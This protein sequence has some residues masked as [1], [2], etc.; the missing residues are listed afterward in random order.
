MKQI[1]CSLQNFSVASPSGIPVLNQLNLNI[2]S[3]EVILL[4]GA[5]GSG[6]STLLNA[7]SGVLDQQKWTVS[8]DIVVHGHSDNTVHQE[9]GIGSMVFQNFAL[10]DELT[11]I[12]NVHIALDHAPQGGSLSHKSLSTLLD[13]VLP[14]ELIEHMSGGQKQR[15]AI[16]RT[17]HSGRLVLLFDEPN[18]GLDIVNTCALAKKI[19]QLAEEEKRAVIIVAHHFQGFL[20]IIDRVWFLGKNGSIKDVEPQAEHIEEM[21]IQ[22]SQSTVIQKDNRSETINDWLPEGRGFH[23]ARTRWL[24]FFFKH[25]FSQLCSS[26]LLLVYM[27]IGGIL[28]GFVS[29]WF[30]IQNLP[31]KRYLLEA[32]HDELLSG[33]GFFQFRVL[34]PLITS[35][36]LAG[37]NGAIISADLGHRVHASQFK[38]MRNLRLPYKLYFFASMVVN[39]ILAAW[40]MFAVVWLIAAWVSLGTWMVLYPNHH[41]GIWHELFFRSYFTSQTTLPL[42]WGWVASKMALSGVACSIAAIVAGFSAKS[43]VLDINRGI[44]ISLVSG[45]SAV[46]LIHTVFAFLEF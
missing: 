42:G 6:K 7:L 20:S 46:L 9:G 1:L 37:R 8:G 17:L 35:L 33:V 28:T 22:E 24:Y 36:L 25:Y 43:S 5:S 18:S 34:A 13:D 19:K 21:L 39:S 27:S 40:L 23:H 26:P 41:S 31:Y 38:A 15:V 3:G 32:I 30:S 29:V 2:H 14:N 11:A 16:A 4:S 45:I 44:A 12:E 10:F